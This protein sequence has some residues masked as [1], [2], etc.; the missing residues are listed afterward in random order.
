MYDL[1]DMNSFADDT[2]VVRWNKLLI[3]VVN[4]MESLLKII[5]KWLW[6]STKD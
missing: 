5:K 6:Q 4:E 3:N 2:Q 1:E